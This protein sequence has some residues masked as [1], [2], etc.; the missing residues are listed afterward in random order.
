MKCEKC[1][2]FHKQT[3]LVNGKQVWKDTKTGECQNRQ[4]YNC[5]ASMVTTAETHC[6][7]GIQKDVKKSGYIG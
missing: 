5:R 3:K 6:G 2:M 7:V 1:I 4:H